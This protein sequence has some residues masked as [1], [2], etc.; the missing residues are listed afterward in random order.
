MNAQHLLQFLNGIHTLEPATI[1]KLKQFLRPIKKKKYDILLKPGDVC[2]KVIFI[3]QG[4]VWAYRQNWKKKEI[5]K[6]VMGEGDVI[7]SVESFINQEPSE[8]FQ[9]AY[10]DIEGYYITY[11]Q[12]QYLYDYHKEFNYIGRVLLEKYYVLSEKRNNAI[13]LTSAK[14][15]F[16]TLQ[17]NEERFLNRVA[18][19]HL[20]SYYGITAETL[21]RQRNGHVQ[22]HSAGIKSRNS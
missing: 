17:K 3:T 5:T 19:K 15:R 20:A 8:E 22:P 10:E 11:K 18:N 16:K 9:I 13:R 7:F 1:A 12:L 14:E 21:S 4:I 6:W 2:E